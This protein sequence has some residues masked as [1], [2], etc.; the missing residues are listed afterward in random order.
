MKDCFIESTLVSHRPKGFWSWPEVRRETLEGQEVPCIPVSLMVSREVFGGSAISSDSPWGSVLAGMLDRPWRMFALACPSTELCAHIKPHK[1]T[2]KQA[3]SHQSFALRLRELIRKIQRR[4]ARCPSCKVT[5]H[6]WGATRVPGQIWQ[7]TWPLLPSVQ[8][9]TFVTARHCVF[10]LSQD[11]YDFQGPYVMSEMKYFSKF[12][13][14]PLIP[15]TAALDFHTAAII[16][17]SW[18]QKKSMI[19][20]VCPLSCFMTPLVAH[21]LS[22]GS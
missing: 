2:T 22:S 5:A 1:E 6:P 20:L 10:N 8:Q 4:K 14:N 18:A 19:S 21:N 3:A 17:F 15:G 7:G 11:L 16:C 9:C 13:K 12:K